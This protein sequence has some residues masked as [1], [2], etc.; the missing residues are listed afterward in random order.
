M[1]LGGINA[2]FRA[3]EGGESLCKAGKSN[4]IISV[5]IEVRVQ[6][7]ATLFWGQNVGK[8]A[9][10]RKVLALIWPKLAAGV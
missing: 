7:R 4:E 8:R 2:Q 1:S 9:Q 10:S 3:T 6:G 5:A